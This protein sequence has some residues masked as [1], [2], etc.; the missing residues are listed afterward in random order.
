MD[1]IL[2]LVFCQV[3]V[4][5]LVPLVVFLFLLIFSCTINCLTGDANDLGTFFF[6]PNK[7]LVVF[8]MV[9]YRPITIRLPIF[10][11]GLLPVGYSW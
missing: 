5:A 9:A 7:N 11:G 3:S 4:P 6:K 1:G 10:N 8:G 2:W